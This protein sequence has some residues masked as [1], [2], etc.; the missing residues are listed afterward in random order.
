MLAVGAV[1]LLPSVAHATTTTVNVTS[2][3]NVKQ[4]SPNSN[5]GDSLVP[6]APNIQAQASATAAIRGYFQ[7]QFTVPAG[8]TIDSVTLHLFAKNTNATGVDISESATGW[9]ASTL[10]WN[11][12]PGVGQFLANSGAMTNGSYFTVD[13]T[14]D[15][16]G[17]T[18]A[19][20]ESFVET[21]TSTTALNTASVDDTIAGRTPYIT[22]VSS[23]HSGHTTDCNVARD[24]NAKQGVPNTNFG[25]VTNIASSAAAS[26]EI[27]GY[28]A[29]DC[30]VPAGETIDTATFHL[31]SKNTDA[32][33]M[34]IYNALG[35]F[36][37][38]TL[39]WNNAPGVGLVEGTTGA[40]TNGTY[41]LI[42][43]TDAFA[44]TTGS[45][46]KDFV[47]K[48]SNTSGLNFASTDDTTM[49]RTPF[50]EFTSSI[51][52]GST[53]ICGQTGSGQTAGGTL[54]HVI[55]VAM[56]NHSKDQILGTGT[57]GTTPFIHHVATDCGVADHYTNSAVP[58]LPNYID[59]FAGQHPCYM[60]NNTT[61]GIT[62]TA[63]CTADVDTSNADACYSADNNIFNQLGTAN[64]T[65]YG[66]G[67]GA[68]ACRSVN[69]GAGYAPRHQPTLYFSDLV[70]GAG[71][72][73]NTSCSIITSLPSNL[74]TIDESKKLTFIAPDLCHDMHSLQ[75]ANDGCDSA[76]TSPIT[77][78]DG[79]SYSYTNTYA[80]GCWDGTQ[81]IKDCN[82]EAGDQ[83]LANLVPALMA[84][85][86]Y[87]A[88]RTAIILWWD[89]D[90][91][92]QV[93]PV[94]MMV[95]SPF[96]QP[97][98]GAGMPTSGISNLDLG[99]TIELL[100]GQGTLSDNATTAYG[101]SGCAATVN[102]P[103]VG[104][105]GQT[106]LRSY[107]HLN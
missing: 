7:F 71:A 16:I 35:D 95:I 43:A 102:D 11:N 9:N 18:G 93:L 52:G 5:F 25:T 4:A 1:A 94:T 40:M 2:D 104:T 53:G 91:S 48:T 84:N 88:G 50:V 41:D 57:D 19:V 20:S 31:F 12:Q 55:V 98:D 90:G 44:G 30:T 13:L 96:S 54:D 56:E 82:V 74:S 76:L 49:G 51:H 24:A 17:Q 73:K 32:T 87:Q 59:L 92:S 66:E 22:V 107:F 15:F 99:Y 69:T 81:N 103:G 6:P 65:A 101:C 23:V 37:Q 62:H 8:E 21:T 46:T 33:G 58:S 29:F 63:D 79:N 70:G 77:G 28:F 105:A 26:A 75:A 64:F 83:Y 85:S 47:V 42:D 39:T 10:T 61:C 106:G 86:T 36:D 60:D 78:G 68:G 89:E 45:F 27:D 100:L 72:G 3:S 80:S 34:T 38:T 14:Q 97:G 67:L